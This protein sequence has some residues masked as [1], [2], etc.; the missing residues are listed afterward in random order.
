PSRAATGR[1]PADRPNRGP[2]RWPTGYSAGWSPDGR[3]GGLRRATGPVSLGRQLRWDL[4]IALPGVGLGLFHT[5]PVRVPLP[6][7]LPE[8]GRA[9]PDRPGSPGVAPS[10]PDHSL[11][12]D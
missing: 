10:A 7:S 2:T 3:R 5:T 12:N 8:P 4:P 9:R 1:R 11:G 6:R